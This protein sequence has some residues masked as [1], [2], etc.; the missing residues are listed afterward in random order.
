M[1]SKLSR[2]DFIRF[3]AAGVAGA[4][5]VPS[6]LSAAT[7]SA[8]KKTAASDTVNIGFIG[9][10]QQAMYLLRGFVSVPG[11]RVVAGA[12]L[13]D[14]KRQRFAERVKKHYAEAKQ[15]IDV[16]L[17]DHYEDLLAR[18]DIDGVV[19]ATPDHYHAIIAIAACRAGK[20]VYL[21]KPLTFTIFE[22]QQLVKAVRD[23]A[24]ILQ[25]GSQQRSSPEFIH[26]ANFL[27]EGK[28]GKISHVKVH[29]GTPPFPRPYDYTPQEIPTGLDW[30]RWRGPL[31]WDVPYNE[32][33]DP[34]VSLS[35]EVN[36][37]YWAEWRY[38]KETG[39]GYMTDWGAHM[40]D[41][42]QWSLGKD[43]T[44]PVEIIPPGFSYHDHLTYKYDNG[45]EMTLQ[46][47]E[48]G[49]ACRF[50]GEG[51][52]IHVRRGKVMA[53]DPAYLP[54]AESGDDGFAY[55]T[56]VPHLE[57]FIRSMRSRR[58]P[59]VPVEIGHSSC[60]VCTL[61]NIA[62]ELGRPLHWNPIVEK[63][64]GG[65]PEATARLHYKYREGYSL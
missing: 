39:G 21:E 63:F 51:G 18:P 35:P 4:V 14:V 25:V 41:I 5:L 60:T 43:R 62:H 30:D 36:E 33:L 12:D 9:L 24:R 19:I 27:R 20:D 55:E 2:R 42:A 7:S 3:S 17:Y 28:L 26:V 6:A 57:T 40:F 64:V 52:W 53:S 49:Q 59:N 46:P 45:I 11:V 23:G 1:S 13:Y 31:S 37:T 38:I 56:N 15:K 16:K 54:T 34:P 47:L 8:V 32:R 10:G 58:D 50:Y 29:V 65:D 61:G 22:G 48:G 44:G